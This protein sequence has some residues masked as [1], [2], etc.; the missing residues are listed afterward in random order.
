M[1]KKKTLGKKKSPKELQQNHHRHHL[2][3]GAYS[4]LHRTDVTETDRERERRSES[5]R[6]HAYMCARALQEDRRREESGEMRTGRRLRAQVEAKS[7]VRGEDAQRRRKVEGEM[8]GREKVREKVS[9]GEGAACTVSDY[10][11][12]TE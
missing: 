6:M 12:R 11:N 7:D 9:R 10:I 3:S 5:V 2:L 8:P 1:G 4:S